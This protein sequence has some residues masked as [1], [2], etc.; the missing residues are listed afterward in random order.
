[1]RGPSLLALALLLG[2]VT[3]TSA[4]AS[5]SAGASPSLQRCEPPVVPADVASAQMV[6]I[7][8]DRFARPPAGSTLTCHVR[9]GQGYGLSHA[10]N[11]TAATWL[12]STHI[13]CVVPSGLST[14]DG[15]LDV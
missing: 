3:T 7:V 11:N 15:R 10:A 9:G 8:G 2:T 12:N 6:V 13:A 4:S 5:A 14:F 1:M